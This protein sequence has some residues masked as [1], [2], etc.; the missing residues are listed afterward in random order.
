MAPLAAVALL[1]AVAVVV[2]Q[3]V[4]VRPLASVPAAPSAAAA[5][6][7]FGEPADG[8]AG[9]PAVASSSGAA[10]DI[11]LHGF[12]I[13]PAAPAPA[14]AAV[15]AAGRPWLLADQAGRVVALF[16][17]YTHCPDVCPQTLALLAATKAALGP[18]ADRLTVAMVTVDR[19]RDTPD[20]LARYMAGFDGDFV[21]L[22]A[23]AALPAA[24]DAFGARYARDLPPALATRAAAVAAHDGAGD[25]AHADADEAH[26]DDTDSH[27]DEGAA[28]DDHVDG[29]ADDAA[30]GH[31]AGLPGNFEPGTDAYTVAHSGV[32][33][34]IDPAGRLR[35][36]H[37]PPFDPAELAG[38]I[39]R[40]AAD[41]AA[42]ARRR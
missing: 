3:V 10:A 41:G 8:A 18:A 21:G 23:G 29:A 4:A 31:A 32:V 40:L 27:D 37:L 36:A 38:D 7:V 25:D 39:A 26:A 1:A 9:D 34:I 24:A 19:E 22:D 5:D 30:S 12:V 35:A 15:D 17:G 2:R 33:F 14:L 11:A 20:V 42:T 16:F 6:P 28:G 13:E